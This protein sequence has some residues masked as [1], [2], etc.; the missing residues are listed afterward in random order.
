MILKAQVQTFHKKIYKKSRASLPFLFTFA[1]A[2][3]GFLSIIQALEKNY[4]AAIY[5]LLGAGLMDLLDGRVA[6]ALNATSALGAEL[7]SLADAISFCLAPCIL[8]YAWYSDTI[9]YL[10]IFAL[11]LYLLAGI[12]RLAKFN[13]THQQQSLHFIG[14]PTPVAALCVTSLILYNTWIAHQETQ[15]LLYKK[16]PFILII[17]LAFLM[18]SSIP[19]PN[20][21]K[22]SLHTVLLGVLGIIGAWLIITALANKHFPLPLI[23][24]SIYIIVGIIRWLVSIKNS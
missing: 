7:D 20:I 24:V 6:R 3:L 5:C 4:T 10:G 22:Q 15:F 9:G 16:T 18:I 12:F 8:L 23:L 19:F 1:N 17:S 21:K 2:G 13:I 11:V 14:L